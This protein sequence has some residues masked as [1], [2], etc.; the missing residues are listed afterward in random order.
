MTSITNKQPPKLASGLYWWDFIPAFIGVIVVS[1]HLI[2]APDNWLSIL[3][4]SYL[5][6]YFAITIYR[7]VLSRTKSEI[8]RS[9]ML[10]FVAMSVTLIAINAQLGGNIRLAYASVWTMGLYMCCVMWLTRAVLDLLQ[11]PIRSGGIPIWLRCLI[12]PPYVYASVI[13]VNWAFDNKAIA[14]DFLLSLF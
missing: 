5:G 10:T 14:G 12:I 11:T 6:S 2:N 4:G 3:V 13:F 8:M 9:V 7:G 1:A